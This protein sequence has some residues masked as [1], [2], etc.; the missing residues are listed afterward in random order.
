MSLPLPTWSSSTCFLRR[1]VTVVSVWIAWTSG[2]TG[3]CL[4]LG[5]GDLSRASILSHG[6]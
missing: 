1:R 6:V 3:D 5:S 2:Y 4:R